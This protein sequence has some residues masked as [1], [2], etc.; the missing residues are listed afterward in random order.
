M[1]A[2]SI[3]DTVCRHLIIQGQRAAT[4]TGACRYRAK[5]HEGVVLKCAVG[6][7]IPDAEYQPWMDDTGPIT[8]VL[9]RARETPRHMTPTLALL[10]PH[11]KVLLRLQETHDDDDWGEDNMFLRLGLRGIAPQFGLSIDVLVAAEKEKGLPVLAG[12]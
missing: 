8:S 6:V 5:D 1:D 4:S 3:F 12:E 7:L 2:Q 10:D 9:N 11:E